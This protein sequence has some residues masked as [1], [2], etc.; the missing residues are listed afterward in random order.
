MKTPSEAKTNVLSSINRVIFYLF[1]DKGV[2]V[3]VTYL[4]L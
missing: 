3:S 2:V 1:L 4:L